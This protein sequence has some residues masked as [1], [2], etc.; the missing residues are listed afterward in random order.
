MK[1]NNKQLQ[2]SLSN[3]IGT[4]YNIYRALISYEYMEL[5]RKEKEDCFFPCNAKRLN[6][7][8]RNLFN[9]Y[10]YALK[11]PRINQSVL[12]VTTNSEFKKIQNDISL[13]GISNIDYPISTTNNAFSATEYSSITERNIIISYEIDESI[14]II[15]V[16]KER[17][18]DYC[19][20]SENEVTIPCPTVVSDLEFVSV[21]KSGGKFYKAKIERRKLNRGKV[22]YHD[23]V[24]KRRMIL[25]GANEYCSQIHNFLLRKINNLDDECKEWLSNLREFIF[26]MYSFIEERVKEE[27]DMPF[28]VK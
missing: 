23:L 18:K 8:L 12:R 6:I 3:Y 4:D 13:N 28:H 20:S 25:N 19:L 9:L 16:V 2:W 21:S 5:L 22:Q 26:D 11:T 17:G 27:K 24:E 14:P 7:E 15:D 10:L 1:N